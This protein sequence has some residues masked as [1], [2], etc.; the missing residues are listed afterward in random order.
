MKLLHAGAIYALANVASAGVPFLLLPL[1]TRVLTP[2]QYG[3]VVNFFLLVTASSAFA[4]LSVHGAVG[5][6]WFRRRAQ[7][8]G[9]V[10]GAAVLVAMAST[11]VVATVSGTV[12]AWLGPRAP[13]GPAWGVLAAATAGANVLLQ[14]RLVL[15]QSQKRPLP[16]A[17][18][19]VAASALN[20]ALSLVAVLGLH[21]AGLGRNAAAGAA[22]LAMAVVALVALR[23][24][25]LLT[26]SVP[27]QELVVML[28]FGLPLV[29]HALGGILMTL[30]DRFAVSTM[31][32]AAQLGVYGAAAQL[33][34]AVTILADAFV[35][36]YNPWLYEKLESRRPGDSLCA[37]GMMYL[38]LPASLVLAALASVVLVALAGVLLGS[39]FQEAAHLL[40][41][42]AIGGAMTAAY[43]IVS[44]LFFF[45]GR[46][47]LLSSVTLPC[48]LVGAALTMG[49]ASRFGVTGAA[50]GYATTQFLLAVSVWLVARRSFDLPW[51]PPA[52]AVAA[53]YRQT[54]AERTA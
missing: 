15:W 24:G 18:T 12:L 35:K 9:Q 7:E 26:W 33:G 37:V 16:M 53:W 54:F 6:A 42:F 17:A 36:A 20:V 46:T 3:D 39:A 29:P 22:A 28:G 45:S 43:L 11:V 31:L 44:A 41:W 21:A 5:V 51:H 19:Q 2:A 40:P 32:G 13:L 52:L 27:R 50:A 23:R 8:V 10:V 38:C 34:M 47:A 49:L 48:A 14:C 4:G 25:G 30:S 1:L